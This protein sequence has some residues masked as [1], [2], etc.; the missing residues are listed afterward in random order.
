MYGCETWS[1]TLREERR[2][3]VLD[4]RMLGRIFGSK[5]DEVT[6]ELKKLLNEELLTKYCSSD[7]IE[8]NETDG[9]RCAYGRRR[10]V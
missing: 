4:N 8:K 9:V 7:Q 2:L 3:K 6:G 10:G 5:G 1:F